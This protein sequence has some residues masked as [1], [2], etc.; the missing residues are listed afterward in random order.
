MFDDKIDRCPMSFNG[1][2]V[3]KKIKV[4][5]FVV[6]GHAVGKIDPFSFGI[7]QSFSDPF[8]DDVGQDRS[9]DAADPIDHKISLFNGFDR[10]FGSLDIFIIEHF[11]DVMVVV[12]N[13]GCLV[14]CQ[15]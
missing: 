3:I 5:S 10:F 6:L 2:D 14:E 9:I 13:V 1:S 15:V 7:V 12:W 8:D 4:K 11:F